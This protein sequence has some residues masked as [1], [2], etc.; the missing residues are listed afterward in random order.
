VQL[1]EPAAFFADAPGLVS[2]AFENVDE[3][4]VPVGLEVN[5]L[6]GHRVRVVVVPGLVV[7][8]LRE[9]DACAGDELVPDSEFEEPDDYVGIK[10][11]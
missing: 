2:A 5:S 8:L 3:T 1:G 9:G 11:R 4:L 10:Q 6:P 7:D